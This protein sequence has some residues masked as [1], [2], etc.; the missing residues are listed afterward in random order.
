MKNKLSHPQPAHSVESAKFDVCAK[1]IYQQQVHGVE[2]ADLLAD[3]EVASLQQ[4]SHQF[5]HMKAGA[6]Q[7][8][9]QNAHCSEYCTSLFHSKWREIDTLLEGC[10]SQHCTVIVE[11]EA[12]PELSVM[13]TKTEALYSI[14][15]IMKALPQN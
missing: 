4:R 2:S 14:I 10:H 9:L 1:G 8:L 12:V 7:G 13:Q 5:G 11:K 15:K 6:P 3:A